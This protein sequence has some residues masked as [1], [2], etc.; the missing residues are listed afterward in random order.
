MEELFE[1]VR[2]RQ[3]KRELPKEYRGLVGQIKSPT[4]VISLASGIIGNADREH[5]L[6]IC[7]NVKNEV[8]AIHIAH[9]GSINACIVHPRE[10][11]KSA[12]LNNAASIIIAHNHPSYD[13]RPSPEDIEVTERIKNA[14][15]IIGIEL[16]DHIIVNDNEGLSLKQKGYL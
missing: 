3:E 9:I 8:T 10:I 4:D 5:M 1:V 11:F 12:I 15:L 2:I 7:L 14:G 6:V 13:L 16:I